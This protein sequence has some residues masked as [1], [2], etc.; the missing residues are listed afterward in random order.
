MKKKWNTLRTLQGCVD[1]VSDSCSH[2][3]WLFSVCS[4]RLI[5]YLSLLCFV[6][7]EAPGTTS[8]G[9]VAGARVRFSQRVKGWEGQRVRRERCWVGFWFPAPYADWLGFWQWL[10]SFTGFPVNGG[11]AGSIPE[12]GRSPGGGHGNPLQYSCLGNPMDRGALQATVHGVSKSWTQLRDLACT[13][14][15]SQEPQI[16]LRHT[17]PIATALTLVTPPPSLGSLNPK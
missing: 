3:C 17:S 4:C 8:P 5:F 2:L 1:V 10:Q 16:P 7:L 11:D 15:L 9:S 12:L 14:S 13:H 6:L